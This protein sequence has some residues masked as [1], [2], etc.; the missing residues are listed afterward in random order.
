MNIPRLLWVDLSLQRSRSDLHIKFSEYCRIHYTAEIGA[1]PKVIL[2]FSPQLLCFEYDYPDLPGLRALQRTK[3]QFSS[4]PVLMLTEYHSESLAIW[5]LRTRVWDYFV[6]PLVVKDILHRIDILS[7]LA[8]SQK[9]ESTRANY[10]P[11][12]Y[13]P[14]EVRFC[15]PTIEKHRTA[16]AIS[17]IEKYYSGNIRVADVARIC[18]LPQAQ[19]S[20]IFKRE[21]A[22]T[23]R[24]FLIRHRIREAKKLLK[25]PC[26]SVTDVGFA[27]GFSDLSDFAEI[28]RRYV[29]TSPL[30]YK[31]GNSDSVLAPLSV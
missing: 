11:A 2:E 7:K 17:Y 15:R 4:L 22:I 28:F 10:M 1:I 26:A 23:F 24:A 25:N 6:K 18:G 20:L 30:K 9:Q 14:N 16:A 19:F 8:N 3:L 12:A 29:G 21:Q 31:M 27:V 5:A 13:I